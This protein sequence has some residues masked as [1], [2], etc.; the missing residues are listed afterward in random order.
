M[1]C[2]G[3]YVLERRPQAAYAPSPAARSFAALEERGS[4]GPLYLL[5]LATS[6][7]CGVWRNWSTGVTL[8][9]L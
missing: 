8:S 3:V 7:T 9:I 5:N 1:R 6:S 4:K 2:I